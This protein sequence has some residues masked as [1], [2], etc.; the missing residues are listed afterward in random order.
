MGS[1]ITHNIVRIYYN[2][3]NIKLQFYMEIINWFSLMFFNRV[4]L[5]ISISVNT[6]REL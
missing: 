2:L 6:V 5:R 4:V 3:V 1:K